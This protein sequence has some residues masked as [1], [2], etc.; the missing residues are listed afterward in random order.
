MLFSLRVPP[1]ISQHDRHQSLHHLTLDPSTASA[2][3]ASQAKRRTAQDPPQTQQP[4]G[5]RRRPHRAEHGAPL[6]PNWWPGGTRLTNARLPLNLPRLVM[7]NLLTTSSKSSMLPNS[8]GLPVF[9]RLA[10]SKTSDPE[11]GPR[12]THGAIRL[13]KRRVVSLL[14]NLF[15]RNIKCESAERFRRS[16][17]MAEG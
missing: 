16:S 17:A 9:N 13:W 2:K 5:R 11:S 10:G 6:A 15:P 14:L 4:R 12:I 1:R 7:K 8:S 3:T